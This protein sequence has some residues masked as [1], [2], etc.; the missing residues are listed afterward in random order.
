MKKIVINSNAK[1]NIGLRILKKKD[2]GYHNIFTIFQEIDLFDTI[3]I[4]K[5]K[6][7][8][9]FNSNVGWLKNDEDNLC[10]AAYRLMR[11]NYNID[12]INIDL[13]K[14]I[15]PGSGLGAGS[16]NAA[17]IMKAICKIYNLKITSK[18]LEH[19]AIN[20]GADVPFFI[21][22]ST[23]L[24]EGVGEKLT[25]LKQKVKGKY[26]IIIPDIVIDTSWAFS[27]FK[28]GLD[29]FKSSINFASLLND[30][31]PSF[32][33]LKLIEN[34]FESIVVPA[35]PEIGEIKEQLCALGA[36]YAS[37]SGSGSTVFGIFN[38]DVLLKSAFSYFTPKYNT[39]I[40][41]PI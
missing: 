24:G 28:N 19:L 32:N 3:T 38:D 9:S 8:C 17:S 10:I 29:T 4:T 7:R 25:P 15:P 16:S 40:S 2:N 39:F 41:D 11:K 12:G 26:L 36:Q 22:G 18:E 23:Q 14:R 35:Y 6:N 5:N 33:K 37:L 31:V 1:V 30:K 21:N 13:I 20:I 34:D 27:K